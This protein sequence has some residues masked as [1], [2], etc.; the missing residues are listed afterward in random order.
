VYFVINF[1]KL[2]R[3]VFPDGMSF[4]KIDWSEYEPFDCTINASIT[5]YSDLI[6][7]DLLLKTRIEDNYTFRPDHITLHYI[8]GSRMDRQ[9]DGDYSMPN[10]CRT[11]CD[12]IKSWN[13]PI[14]LVWPHSTS[15]L[16][17]LDCVESY[18]SI[19]FVRDG[20]TWFNSIGFNKFAIATPDAG[21]N[22][23][24]WNDLSKGIYSDCGDFSVIECGKHREVTTGRLSG[25]SCPNEVPENIIILDDLCDGGGTFSGLASE[26]RKHGA[27]NIGLMVYHGIFSKGYPDLI[28]YVYTTNSYY[29]SDSETMRS[30]IIENTSSGHRF[31]SDHINNLSIVEVI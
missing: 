15:L 28:D 5:S 16:D 17:R 8:I 21:M 26:L 18:K 29:C 2:E 10:V 11:V 4:R 12:V 14:K 20:L 30:R 24:W 31:I 19:N 9:I 25:F 1:N 22:K 23:R 7:L 3:Q 13:I 6:E 27:K